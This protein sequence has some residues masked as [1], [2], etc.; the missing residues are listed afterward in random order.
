MS[1]HQQYLQQQQQYFQ[2]K[3]QQYLQQ[4]KVMNNPKHHDSI[5]TGQLQK[6]SN[7]PNTSKTIPQNV[8]IK[9]EAKKT[10]I[11]PI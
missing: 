4:Q 5:Q 8:N 1:S 9:A 10:G 3:Q 11:F 7:I 2:Q 6:E